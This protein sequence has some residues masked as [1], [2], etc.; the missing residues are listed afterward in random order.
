MS[1]SRLVRYVFVGG[2]AYVI[3]MGVLFALQTWLYFSNVA[4]VAISFWVGFLVAFV[5]QKYI[6]FQN[7]EASRRTVA[8]QLA[9]YSMLVAWNYLFTLGLVALL[10][11]HIPAM[12][13]RTFAIIVITAWN[14]EF[15]KKI[16]KPAA[17]AIDGEL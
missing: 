11:Q 8:R 13:S 16:F 10:G 9:A 15:Y 17:N 7:H 5:L 6:A 14:Y 3:E 12:F 1:S 4:A 2:F